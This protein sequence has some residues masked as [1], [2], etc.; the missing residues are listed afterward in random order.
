MNSAMKETGSESGGII[1]SAASRSGVKCLGSSPHVFLG[2]NPSFV[3]AGKCDIA[4]CVGIISSAA[5]RIR[6]ETQT[7]VLETDLEPEETN[8]NN[9]TGVVM[10]RRSASSMGA[11]KTAGKKSPPAKILCCFGLLCVVMTAPP[12]VTG[13]NGATGSHSPTIHL[14]APAS[15]PLPLPIPPGGTTALKAAAPSIKNDDA[16]GDPVLGSS[17]FQF[18]VS[19]APGQRYSIEASPNLV[20]WTSVSTNQVSTFGF[21]DFTDAQAG[22]VPQRFYRTRPLAGGP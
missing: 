18:R 7:N 3:T 13:S 16:A 8:T 17:R 21:S 10:K 14:T 11:T 9:E 4:A 6:K 20:N 5:K 19:G 12:S 1:I 22:A 2:F 15:S